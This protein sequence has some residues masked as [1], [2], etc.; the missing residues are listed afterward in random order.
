MVTAEKHSRLYVKSYFASTIE[1]SID[2]AHEE[3]GA[4]ALLMNWRESPPEARAQ[5]VYE[6]VFG[7]KPAVST[8]LAPVAAAPDPMDDLR[9]RMEELREMVTRLSSARA[10][11]Q[12]GSCALVSPSTTRSRSASVCSLPT[13][14]KP[15]LESAR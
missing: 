2:K 11:V 1:E 12:P 5:G 15:A 10:A 9:K 6:V 4:D 8:E 13:A 7:C 14:Q 3:L